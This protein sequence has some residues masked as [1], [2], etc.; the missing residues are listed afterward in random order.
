M[1]AAPE[2]QRVHSLKTFPAGCGYLIK[3]LTF[4]FIYRPSSLWFSAI[5]WSLVLHVKGFLIAEKGGGVLWFD[6][7]Q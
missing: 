3:V 6:L 4:N 5:L 1:A 7:P 2:P